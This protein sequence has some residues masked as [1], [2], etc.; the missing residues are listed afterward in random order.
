[1][2]S[3]L[4]A[5]T[6][7]ITG[8][9]SGIGLEAARLFAQSG[10]ALFLVGRDPARLQRVATET[11][12]QAIR[13]DLTQAEELRRVADTVAQRSGR[14]DVLVNCAGRLEVGPTRELG[15]A[16]AEALMR[17]NFFAPVALTDA[18][19]PL[20]RAGVRAS[21]V[22]VASIAG[23]VSPPFMAA[24]AA[25]KHALVA[26]TRTLRQELRSEGI[27]VGLVLPAPVATPMLQA[28]FGGPYYP[29]PPGLP[30]VTATEAAQAILA[31]AERRYAER[32]VPRWLG[33]VIGLQAAFP[34]LTE[35]L[36]RA[37]GVPGRG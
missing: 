31:C 18:C 37:M 24:Y 3:S 11:G 4:S 32:T 30:V 16:T 17:V 7:L 12:A 27:H 15:A 28:S 35:L 25:S 6:V 29:R 9:S 20:L 1:M 13:A 14:L 8:A 21:V 34:G 23:R 26:Y 36:Y 10:A 33:G 22:N 19:L 5:R 2:S